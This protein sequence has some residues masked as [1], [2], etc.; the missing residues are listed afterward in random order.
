M[1]NSGGG[2]DGTRR[3]FLQLTVHLPPKAG[4]SIL[5][6]TTW[7]PFTIGAD[8]MDMFCIGPANPALAKGSTGAAG[9]VG[10]G[11]ATGAGA[12][13]AGVGDSMPIPPSRST[14]AADGMAKWWGGRLVERC[15][16]GG[17]FDGSVWRGPVRFGAVRYG[18][19]WFSTFGTVGTDPELWLT[20]KSP[21]TSTHRRRGRGTS[22]SHPYQANLRE[23]PRRPGR[24]RPGRR[25]RQ[26]AISSLC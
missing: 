4:V 14:G 11:T 16:V 21:T 12:G 7:T 24:R 26:R 22:P 19:V 25:P 6:G 20:P 10:V 13:A 15:V 18:S 23:E 17:R 5:K 2:G 1:G 3:L 9:G 8:D